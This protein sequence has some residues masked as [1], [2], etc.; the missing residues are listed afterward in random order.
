MNSAQE[1][2]EECVYLHVEPVGS[3]VSLHGARLL[4]DGQ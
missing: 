3:V 2:F 4:V 1:R